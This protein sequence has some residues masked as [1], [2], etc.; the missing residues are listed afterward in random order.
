MVIEEENIKKGLLPCGCD[1]GACKCKLSAFDYMFK[2][3]SYI[4]SMI[5][6][7]KKV[8]GKALKKFQN[9]KNKYCDKNDSVEIWTYY[10]RVKIPYIK[11]LK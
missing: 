11:Y 5:K 1:P 8:Y 3:Q 2:Y 9:F 10:D 7:N 6:T 4:G